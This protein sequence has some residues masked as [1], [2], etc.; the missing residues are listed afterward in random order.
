MT[1]ASYYSTY[2]VHLSINVLHR[3]LFGIH[4]KIIIIC[5]ILFMKKGILKTIDIKIVS[6]ED[7][8]VFV[9]GF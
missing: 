3:F 9:Y 8:E 6:Q 7:V 2:F 5:S 1:S 4:H